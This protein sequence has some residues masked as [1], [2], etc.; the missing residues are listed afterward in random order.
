M[1]RWKP[2]LA[3]VFLMIKPAAALSEPPAPKLIDKPRLVSS[4]KQA[5]TIS[6]QSAAKVG[7]QVWRNETGGSRDAIT[8]W[9]TAE[10]FMSL[11]IG[12]FIW[13]P[14][15]LRS[16]FK[17]SFPEMLEFLRNHGATPPTWLSMSPVV[18]CPWKT[19]REFLRDFHSSKMTELRVFLLNTK[20][21]QAQF[22]VARMKDALPKILASI[23]NPEDLAHVRHQ[24]YR[25]VAAS[26][27]LYPLI[28][29]INFKGEGTSPSETFPNRKT[30]KPEGWG[31]KDVLLVMNGT[32]SNPDEVLPEFADAAGFALK[33]R[34]ANNPRD[35]RWR[36]GWLSRIQTYRHPLQ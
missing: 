32:S 24:F 4:S 26:K 35:K 12:H 22:L 23:P 11:G 28:D 20:G 6:P 7:R 19:K 9:N 30:G 13:F 15:D 17:E 5:I 25:V 31:L 2:L 34:I 14:E 33:R 10:D 36:R 1:N 18:P 8:A 21:L 27:D 3:V 16:K 29:Y